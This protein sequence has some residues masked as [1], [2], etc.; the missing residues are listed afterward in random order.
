MQG[1]AF[2][3]ISCEISIL[4]PVNTSP[5]KKKRCCCKREGKLH[6]SATALKPLTSEV[7]NTDYMVQCHL[8]RVGRYLD[9]M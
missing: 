1:R 2:A 8:S 7:N 5:E 3:V 9:S 6:R 4:V